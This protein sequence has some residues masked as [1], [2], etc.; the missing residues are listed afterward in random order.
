MLAITIFCIIVA[1][2]KAFTG[3]P[4]QHCH[5]PC[6]AKSTPDK[7]FNRYDDVTAAAHPAVVLFFRVGIMHDPLP[8]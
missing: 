4:K 3:V 6:V 1:D 5:G 2:T 8:P 7:V